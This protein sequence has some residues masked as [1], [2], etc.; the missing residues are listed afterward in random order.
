MTMIEVCNLTLMLDAP[1]QRLQTASKRIQ[2]FAEDLPDTA[3]QL[4]YT[5]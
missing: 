1:S 4:T 2:M 3:A 5:A